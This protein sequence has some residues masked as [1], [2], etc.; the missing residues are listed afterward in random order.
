MIVIRNG[1]IPFKGFKAVNLFGVLFVRKDV[2]MTEEDF[3]HEAIHMAQMKE[4]CYV[5]FYVWYVVEWLLRLVWYGS[6]A[7][8]YM[9]I[10]FEREALDNDDDLTY[11]DKRPSCAWMEYL[12]ED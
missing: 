8:A 5:F 9:N 7:G 10:S 6:F 4:L 11:L 3:N 1:I 12:I 2:T